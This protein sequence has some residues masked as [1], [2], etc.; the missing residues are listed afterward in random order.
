MFSPASAL[1]TGHRDIVSGGKGLRGAPHTVYYMALLM[2]NAPRSGAF[3]SVSER[4][5]SL[6]G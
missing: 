6:P 3:F 2:K 4:G 5:S 1:P